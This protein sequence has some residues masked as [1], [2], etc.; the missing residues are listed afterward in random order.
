MKRMVAVLAMVA[1]A[2]CDEAPM[3]ATNGANGQPQ[4]DKC[5][6]TMIP[7]YY[8][9][10]HEVPSVM[11]DKPTIVWECLPPW[12]GHGCKWSIWTETETFNTRE[13]CM[14]AAMSRKPPAFG[15]SPICGDV[16]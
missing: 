13:Q 1:L 5:W 14:Q 8:V 2:G 11:W 6:D 7:C 4:P 3:I 9:I 10:P 12:P 16:E 15:M